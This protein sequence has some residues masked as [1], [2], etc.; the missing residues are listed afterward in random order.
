MVATAPGV[1]TPLGVKMWWRTTDY[2]ER[3]ML[4]GPDA[5]DVFRDP[6]QR[7]SMFG[8]PGTEESAELDEFRELRGGV[9]PR[10]REQ[11]RGV[12]SDAFAE[13][14]QDLEGR[15]SLSAFEQTDVGRV[16]VDGLGDRC[17]RQSMLFSSFA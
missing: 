15:R 1:S 2:I 9:G 5:F 10:F 13:G 16:H 4:F 12:E 6:H 3:W 11:L 7:T 8:W 17:L 14:Q